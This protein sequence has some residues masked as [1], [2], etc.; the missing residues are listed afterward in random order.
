MKNRAKQSAIETS[1]CNTN[2]SEASTITEDESS[3]SNTFSQK[4]RAQVTQRKTWFF[5]WNNPTMEP[6]KLQDVFKSFCKKYIFQEEIAPSTNTPH[7]QG[8]I[9]TNVRCRPTE[10]NL[11]KSIHWEPMRDESDVIHYCSKGETRKPDTLPYYWPEKEFPELFKPR[12]IKLENFY[13]W[14]KEMFEKLINEKPNDR[15]IYWIYENEGNTGK[16]SFVKYLVIH[17]NAVFCDGGKKSD[18]INLIYNSDMI[19]NNIVLFDIPRSTAGNVSYST[20]ESIK[21]GLVCN[22]KY[23]TGYKAFNPPHIVCFAN[24]MP[25][26]PEKLSNDRWRI[27]EINNLELC[28]TE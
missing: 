12:T 1:E 11:P 14:Q 18:L 23:E 5:T 15:T 26:N 17:H 7:Y 25:E 24:F 16:S 28:A 13:P 9:W 21:N 22:T 3:V 19:D 20:L 10:L 6:S 8:G 2:N 4:S 27:Y